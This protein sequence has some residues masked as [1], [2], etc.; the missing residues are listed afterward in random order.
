MT[1]LFRSDAFVILFLHSYGSS[2]AVPVC[3]TCC[4]RC[5]ST[6]MIYRDPSDHLS[7]LDAA[8]QALMPSLDTWRR[9]DRL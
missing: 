9:L 1:K 2:D 6:I 7:H 4:H 3:I 5:A 8:C